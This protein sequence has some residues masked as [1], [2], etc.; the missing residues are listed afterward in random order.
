MKYK[1]KQTETLK[2]PTKNVTFKKGV[3][4]SLIKHTEVRIPYWKFNDLNFKIS[5]RAMNTIF[6]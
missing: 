4:Y 5:R 2:T 6:E 3:K 1:C